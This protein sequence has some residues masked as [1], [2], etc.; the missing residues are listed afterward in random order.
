[1]IVPRL[2]TKDLAVQ[3]PAP[4]EGGVNLSIDDQVQ[5]A[6]NLHLPL[7]TP[8]QMPTLLKLLKQRE[9]ETYEALSELNYVH[10]AR[11]LPARDG[12]ALWVIT[13]Y[14]GDLEPYI[15]DF[16]VKLGGVFTAALYFIK[17]APRLP[18]QRYPRD[19]IDFVKNNNVPAG[20][21]SAYSQLTVIDIRR[22][23]GTS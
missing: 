1:V 23:F 14:D 5:S 11:F 8:M 3:V 18:V 2:G 20:D 10:F 13:V 6:L 17:G 4:V 21:W 9:D 16:V 7:K 15:L 12:S 22:R 19:F